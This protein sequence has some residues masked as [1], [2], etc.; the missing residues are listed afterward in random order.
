M[1]ESIGEASKSRDWRMIAKVGRSLAHLCRV[2]LVT[3]SGVETLPRPQVFTAPT[4]QHATCPSLTFAEV[5][6]NKQLKAA[7]TKAR[8][9]PTSTKTSDS[10]ETIDLADSDSE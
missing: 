10:L 4:N 6:G 2:T 9:A 1:A 8:V 3:D 7:P 5:N